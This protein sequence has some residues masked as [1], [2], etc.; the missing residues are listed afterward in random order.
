MAS[1]KMALPDAPALPKRVV[2]VLDRSGS[3]AGPKIEQARERAGLCPAKPAAR[4]RVQRD[5]V[6]RDRTTS[7]VPIG[8]LPATPDNVKR[9]LAF[10]KGIEAEGGTN[11]HDALDA[12]LKMFPAN[13]ARNGSSSEHG[14]SS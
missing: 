9:G 2:L 11:I 3:M 14:R 4:R 6:Q 5:D 8:L 7:S 1:P 12:A 13:S 10:V